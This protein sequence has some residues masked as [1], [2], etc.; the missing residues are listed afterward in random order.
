M[1]LARGIYIAFVVAVLLILAVP[2][3]QQF[4]DVAKEPQVYSGYWGALST[5]SKVDYGLATA[6]PDKAEPV[7]GAETAA[8]TPSWQQLRDNANS[9]AR[10][11]DKAF[12]D[13]YHPPSGCLTWQSPQQ[14]AECG[15]HKMQAKREFSDRYLKSRHDA[16]Q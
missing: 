15:N 16:T 8:V 2:V 14:M 10:E 1:V 4:F 7:A 12:E 3:K 11:I 9:R 6:Q 5:S 13:W